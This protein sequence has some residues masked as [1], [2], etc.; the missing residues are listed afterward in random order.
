VT[1]GAVIEPRH[2]IW[3]VRHAP[4]SWTG[5][6]WCGRA[7]PPLT[8]AG[9]RAARE[10][11]ERLR[12]EVPRD[13]VVVTSPARRARSTARAIASASGREVIVEPLLVEVDVGRAEGRTWD[14]L[15][16]GDPETAERIV[17]GGAIDWPGGE[18]AVEVAAR[19]AAVAARIRA[20]GRDR[21]TIVVSHGAFLHALATALG[22]VDVGAALEPCG[23]R[24]IA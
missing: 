13:A 22:A 14:E 10:V 17:S 2:P 20:I 16:A 8:V 24:V 11:A 5:R 4:T 23:V 3:L 21:S 12:I 7:D 18:T 19:S 1:R 6:R 9:Q 15:S